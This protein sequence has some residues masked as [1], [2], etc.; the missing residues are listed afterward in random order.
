MGIYVQAVD[1]HSKSKVIMN[2]GENQVRLTPTNP[3]KPCLC[4]QHAGHLSTIPATRPP[5]EGQGIS[6]AKVLQICFL[7]STH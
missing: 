3:Y 4:T 1:E 6:V 2:L 7:L 5:Q